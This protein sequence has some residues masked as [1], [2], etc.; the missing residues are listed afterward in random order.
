MVDITCCSKS[1]VRGKGN[2]GAAVESLSGTQ[3][4]LN[5]SLE[6]AIINLL[7]ISFPDIQVSKSI[8]RLFYYSQ[9]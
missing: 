4:I 2:K 8:T 6:M 9:I 1:G 7:T 3:G 5:P